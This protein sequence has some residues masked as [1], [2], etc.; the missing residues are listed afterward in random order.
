MA[1]ACLRLFTFFPLRPLFNF[2]RF[3]SRIARLTFWP[4]F[5]PYFLGILIFNENF[6]KNL[7]QILHLLNKK[8]VT[9]EKRM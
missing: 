8:T 2:S 5:L 7:L 6:I 9:R 1:I 4:A 3:I